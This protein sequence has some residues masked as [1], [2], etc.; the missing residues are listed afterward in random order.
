MA[1]KQVKKAK[2][3]QVFVDEHYSIDLAMYQ[4]SELVAIKAKID[5]FLATKVDTDDLK[6]AG[7]YTQDD[8]NKIGYKS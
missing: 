7:D 2:W 4:T 8:L 1:K 6:P 3:I 5:E